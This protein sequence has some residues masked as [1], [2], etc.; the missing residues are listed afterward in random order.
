MLYEI[1]ITRHTRSAKH[2]GIVQASDNPTDLRITVEANNDDEAWRVLIES[3]ILATND[4]RPVAGR[5]YLRQCRPSLRPR[6]T[7]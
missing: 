5:S 4:T 6:G 3:V 1:P 2:L 7:T